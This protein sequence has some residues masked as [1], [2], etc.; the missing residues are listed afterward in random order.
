MEQV[1]LIV[2]LTPFLIFAAFCIYEILLAT[3]LW[4]YD[5][6]PPI[7]YANPYKSLKQE[8]WD[9]AI[10]NYARKY[11]YEKENKMEQRYEFQAG[12]V[13]TFGGIECI[14]EANHNNDAYPIKVTAGS[15]VRTFTRDGRYEEHHTE[16]LLKLVR[17][18][19]KKV[20]RYQFAHLHPDGS[21]ILT[22]RYYKDSHELLENMEPLR[23]VRTERLYFT[24]KEFEE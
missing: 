3:K 21:W 14:C 1:G 15:S 11:G 23:P 9:N 22:S 17:K 18:A 6:A 2:I 4:I 13:V 7:E 20:T 19:K 5:D 8:D 12:D 10:I 16:P 24:A